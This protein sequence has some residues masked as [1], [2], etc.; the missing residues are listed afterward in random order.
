MVSVCN[1]PQTI[2]E[3]EMFRP[4]WE[5]YVPA[6]KLP[7]RSQLRRHFPR[8]KFQ[9]TNTVR[10]IIKDQNVWINVDETTD[11]NKNSVINVI[12]RTLKFDG[13][14]IPFVMCSKRLQNSNVKTIV[15]VIK[16]AVNVFGVQ[17]NQ[18]RMFV[19]NGARNMVEVG[20]LLKTDFPHLLHVTCLLHAF[21]LVI[22]TIRLSYPPVDQLISNM[23]K[24]F[25]KSPKRIRQFKNVCAGIPLPSEPILTRW[26]TWLEAVSYYSK[27]FQRI[28]YFIFTLKPEDSEAIQRSQELLS[29][30]QLEVDIAEICEKYSVVRESL[31]Q[32]QDSALSLSESLNIVDNTKTSLANLTDDIGQ[33]TSE[34][35]TNVLNKNPDL[36]KIRFISRHI[37]DTPGCESYEEKYFKYANIT[38]VDV[39]RSFSKYNDVFSP[40]RRRLNE[41]SMEAILMLQFYANSLRYDTPLLASG[42]Q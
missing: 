40:R 16:D 22:D 9:V 4:F 19:T 33:R 6:W 31:E 12:V 13:P 18:L 1:V 26:G 41:S 27:H 7:T 24:I 2:V 25:I 3:Q 5:K 35:F 29:V 36:E 14:S 30:N 10:N 32:L 17:R 23:K 20:R 21:H 8:V 38:S 11:A 39:E 37:N 28:K 15:K 42:R 34:N